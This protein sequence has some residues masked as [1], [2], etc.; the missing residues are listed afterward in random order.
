MAGNYSESVLDKQ[1]LDMKITANIFDQDERVLPRTLSA[2]SGA[3]QN[4][5]CYIGASIFLLQAIGYKL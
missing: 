5:G 4:M 3:M 2:Y 1:V